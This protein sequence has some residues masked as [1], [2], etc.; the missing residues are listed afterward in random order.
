MK[1]R[2]FTL[3]EMLVSV[4][5]FSVVMVMALGA[6]LSLSTADRKAEALKS[7]V[8][9]LNFALDSMS[10]SIRTG[11]GYKCG[12]I[13]GGDCV[14][15]GNNYF[16]FTANNGVPTAYRLESPSVDSLTNVQTSCGQTASVA[17]MCGQTTATAG[18]LER[19][20]NGGSW[21]AI[22]APNVVIQDFSAGNGYPFHVI[23][24]AAGSADNRQPI[25]IMTISGYTQVS[26]SQQGC[27]HV[28][29]SVTQRIYDQ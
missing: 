18:C 11:S 25:V 8:D 24:S 28:Q 2:G 10:R 9:N 3:I 29:S 14:N 1:K 23:G 27:F 20:I 19:S 21:A 7:A 16:Y 12:S 5:L 6:L 13:N 15:P 26:T 17:P 22:T 4:A